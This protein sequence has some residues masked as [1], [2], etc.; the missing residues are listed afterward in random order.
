M[1]EDQTR[2]RRRLARE[3]RRVEALCGIAGSDR[4]A[5]ACCG[6]AEIWGLTFDHRHGGGT[7]HRLENA[8][9]PTVQLVRGARKQTGAWPTDVF[10]VLCA[11]CNHGRR[12][13]PD[14]RCPHEQRGEVKMSRDE[15]KQIAGTVVRVF[16]AATLAQFLAGG[17]D[18]FAVSADAAKTI[19][20]S[21]VAAAALAVFNYVNPRDDR[22][23]ASK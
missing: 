4:P 20:A 11:L 14:G 23:G 6:F 3:R 19:V 18:V 17:A 10:Q 2:E 22:Y 16:V 8:K 9:A 13:S 1:T 15:I 21:G 12:V 5:C 7:Q